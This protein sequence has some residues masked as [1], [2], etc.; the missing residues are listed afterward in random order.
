[1]LEEA[2]VLGELHKQGWTPKRT[3]IYCA[4]DGEEPGLLGSVEWVETHVEDL[5]KH[6]VTY[7]NSDSSSRGFL[8]AGGTQDLQALVADVAHDINDPEK[9]ISVFER[10]H[11]RAIMRAKDAEERGKL[12]KRNDLV[13]CD[14]GDGSDFTAF[15][16]F[17]GIS[18][19]NLGY[20]GEDEGTQYHSI[21]DDYYWYNGDCP[22]NNRLRGPTQH[23]H[24]ARYGELE[25]RPGRRR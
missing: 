7:I 3:I 22:G 10:A 16:D 1:M 8:S 15:Q 5:R 4:W 12:R 21:Y 17:A 23:L 11:L 13:L 18:S 25:H 6:A 2:R 9:N 14:L 19:L 20:G 24:C